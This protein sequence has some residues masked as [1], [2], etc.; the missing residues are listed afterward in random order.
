MLRIVGKLST[1]TKVIGG[2][3][4]FLLISYGI[5]FGLP[6]Q[7]AF[8]YSGADCTRQLTLFPQT[9]KQVTDSNFQVEF[10]DTVLL[11]G[12]PILSLKA[13]FTALKPPTEG[14]NMVNVSPFGPL[15]MKRYA[16]KVEPM[17]AAT[18]GDF[19]GKTL[20]TTR[21]ITIA[22]SGTDTVFDYKF[23][24]A[25]K[26]A[27]CAPKDHTILCDIEELE[28]AQG[29]KYEG[30]LARYFNDTKITELG[31]GTFTTLRALVLGAASASE[32]QTIY[33]KPTELSFEYD[34]PLDLVE[35][36]LKVKNGE[37]YEPVAITTSTDD[38]KAI[39][40]PKEALKRNAQFQLTL[41]KVEAKD[42]S[43]IPD[44]HVVNFTMSGGPKVTGI[45][46]G[47]ISAPQSG[48]IVLTFDQEIANI[49]Q[50]AKLVTITGIGAHIFKNGSS[51]VINYANAPR[52]GDFK[53]SVKKGL[54][55]QHGII[56]E[57]DWNFS[58]RTI[59]YYTQTFGYSAK[60]RALNAW[61]FGSGSKTILYT[62]AIHGNEQVTR[63]LMN[64]WIN[65]LEVNARSIPAGVQIVVVPSINPD[66]VATNTRANANNV[67][68]NRNFN[69]SDWKQDIVTPGNQPWPGGGGSAPMSEPET[70]ALA[71]FTSSLAPHLTLSYHSTAGYAIAN[72][73]GGSAGLA[74]TYSSLSG[75]ANMTGVGGA[76]SYEITGTY[77]DWIC[78]K[79]GRQSVLIELATHSSEFGRN[80]AALWAMARS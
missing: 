67:D 49:D 43:A 19:V 36:E 18:L 47:S 75:Y 5:I 6:K 24:V 48:S 73:C 17:R 2:V 52:C 79:L 70:Q 78:E 8:S 16:L 12:Q 28:L 13:C 9:M 3:S 45:N 25:D 37:A 54:E 15:F 55:S 44:P 65:E 38:K 77:D 71:A 57:E 74:A 41:K 21:P 64:A 27:A 11:M 46:V 76:F 32:G 63:S 68:L 22:L 80:K 58:G 69:V 10:T 53:I 1:R 42:G 33:D 30:T 39:V 60:G 72:G 23:T 20:P 14:T 26:T 62:G 50:I 40:T 59:C 51:I 31:S 61:V 4:L 29:E 66:G 56:Q 34:K 7:V 35:A